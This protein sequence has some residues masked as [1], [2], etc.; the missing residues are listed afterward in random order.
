M[1]LTLLVDSK[2]GQARSRSEANRGSAGFNWAV[3]MREVAVPGT[4]SELARHRSLQTRPF[5]TS[6]RA[7]P[8]SKVLCQGEGRL[9]V[10]VQERDSLSKPSIEGIAVKTAEVLVLK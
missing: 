2:F 3:G 7:A 1:S 4:V 10:E 8:R 9:D 5:P 6:L